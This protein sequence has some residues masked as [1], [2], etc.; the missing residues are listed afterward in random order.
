MGSSVRLTLPS[1][2]G[3]QKPAEGERVPPA[4]FTPRRAENGR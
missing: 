4:Y 3:R 2:K 1:R